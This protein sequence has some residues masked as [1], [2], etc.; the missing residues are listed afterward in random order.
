MN[1]RRCKECGLILFW[2]VSN[3]M[4]G[5]EGTISEAT[6]RNFPSLV[7]E[8]EFIRVTLVPDFGG[9]IAEYI[10]KPSAANQFLPFQAEKKQALPGV[11]KTITNHGGF[12]D[13]FWNIDSPNSIAPYKATILEK[14]PVRLAVQLAWENEVQK[15]ERIVSLSGDSAELQLEVRIT[16]KSAQPATWQYWPAAMVQAG[17][18]FAPKGSDWMYTTVRASKADAKAVPGS[19]IRK[20]LIVPGNLFPWEP[21]AQDWIAVLDR[22]KKIALSFV[23]PGDEL[24][25]DGFHYVWC[26]E[27]FANPN[28]AWP[29]DEATRSKFALLQK[30][31]GA[32]KVPPGATQVYHLSIIG[33]SGL[34]D[35]TYV[36]RRLA[37]DI[38]VPGGPFPAGKGP[39][40]V[41]GILVP[42]SA[43]TGCKLKLCLVNEGGLEKGNI[44]FPIA[45]GNPPSPIATP[46]NPLQFQG[47]FS[48]AGLVPG[49]YG[50]KGTVE[51]PDGKRVEEFD[52]LIPK[53]M[54]QTQ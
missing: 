16:N 8:N 14:G 51:G 30:I 9:R 50:M 15:I 47:G 5:T 49:S 2:L 24:L 4:A 52:L 38:A 43:M 33:F 45:G 44:A 40:P 34:A 10:L 35:L 54:I 1:M 32:R 53:I 20:E 48:T 11:F 28:L 3:L 26:G 42:S 7:L 19:R 21:Q 29:P 31:Y 13:R 41:S 22:D 39:V 23:A 36:G 25:P 6:Y 46:L 37:L 18:D 12:E 27:K 17:G